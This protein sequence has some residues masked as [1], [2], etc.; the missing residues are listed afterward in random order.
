MVLFVEVIKDKNI[1][2]TGGFGLVGSCV[3]GHHRFTSKQIDLV[4]DHLGLQMYLR[5]YKDINT[6]VHCAGLVGGVKRNSENKAKFFHDNSIMGLNVL[7]ACRIENVTK[8]VSLLS[9]CIFPYKGPYPLKPEMIHEGE[10]HPSASGYS[11]AKRMLEIGSN[12]YREQYGMKN[13][14]ISPCNVYGNGD[15]FD[16]NDAHV[17]PALIHR[18]YEAKQKDEPL[19]V[20]GN[21]KARREFILNTDLGKVIDVLVKNYEDEETIIVSPDEDISIGE[22]AIIIAKEM[23]VKGVEFDTSMPEGQ[24]VKP[25]CNAKMKDYIDFSFTPIEIGIRQT[26]QWFKDN[27]EKVKK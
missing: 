21:G 4:K 18:A 27:Y 19:K 16:K 11:Y 25:S 20:W 8:V 13:I 26:C 12:L 23:G 2:V 10:P 6:V 5:K 7:E 3:K 1:L 22:I 15:N 9:T 24:L 14:T 17:I